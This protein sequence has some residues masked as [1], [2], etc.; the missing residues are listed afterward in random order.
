MEGEGRE[1]TTLLFRSP[2][3][4]FFFF[5]TIEKKSYIRREST[6][7]DVEVGLSKRSVTHKASLY[8]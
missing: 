7:P 5:F 1:E 4:L 2:C 3:I 8:S 6:F